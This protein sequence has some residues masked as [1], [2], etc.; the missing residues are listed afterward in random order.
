M[1][2]RPS[3]WIVTLVSVRPLQF[4]S[5]VM[6]RTAWLGLL[7]IA[8]LVG[9]AGAAGTV[10]ATAGSVGLTCERSGGGSV[11]KA[12]WGADGR[13]RRARGTG[14]RSVSVTSGA[15]VFS[16]LIPGGSGELGT[17][18]GTRVNIAA[19]AAPPMTIN[20]IAIGIRFMTHH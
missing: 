12:I 15:D 9:T 8:A 11:S 1:I 20:E 7:S 3:G 18:V 5:L 2:T 6:S 16:A 13:C 19:L 4:P 17:G 10:D 14:L